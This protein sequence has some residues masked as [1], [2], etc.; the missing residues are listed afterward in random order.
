MNTKKT[1]LHKPL[2]GL[3]H[4]SRTC[5]CAYMVALKFVIEAIPKASMAIFFSS[6]LEIV[7]SEFFPSP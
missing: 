2:V 6:S 4:V 5:L 7:T 3:A 1:P